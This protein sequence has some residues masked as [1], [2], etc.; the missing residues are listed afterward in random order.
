MAAPNESPDPAESDL[1]WSGYSGFATL[2]GAVV[3]GLAS[4]VIMLGAPPLG[5][6]FDLP[7]DWTAFVRFWLIFIGWLSVSVVWAYRA[8]SFVYRLTPSRLFVDYGMLY[9]P[10]PPIPLA[11]VTAVDCRAW[12]LRRLFG[13]GTVV[14]RAETRSPIRLHGIFRPERF[15]AAIREAA[16]TARES[17]VR[18]QESGVRSQ[19]SGVKPLTP[20]P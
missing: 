16:A 20:D 6:W 19:E 13:V 11:R 1:Y 15:A 8:A 14:V 17:G 18:S 12:A 9:S 2:P 3:G 5:D 10:V 7:E 4:A